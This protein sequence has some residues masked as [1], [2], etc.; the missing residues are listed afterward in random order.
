[1]AD[2][3]LDRVELRRRI[4]HGRGSGTGRSLQTTRPS[5]CGLAPVHLLQLRSARAITPAPALARPWSGSAGA[6]QQALGLRCRRTRK[7]RARDGSPM[8]TALFLTRTSV[9]PSPHGFVRGRSYTAGRTRQKAGCGPPL[10]GG[11]FLVRTTASSPRTAASRTWRRSV[12]RSTCR[13]APQAAAHTMMKQGSGFLGTRATH[14][15]WHLEAHDPHTAAATPQRAA[16]P[17]PR[18]ASLRATKSCGRA[19]QRPAAA[20]SA[21]TSSWVKKR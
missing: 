6:R 12:S 16:H 15:S 9:P 7:A 4:C 11:T 18:L 20:A 2:K 17:R 19:R 5:G 21:V 8:R 13:G 1:M 14:T 3:R 10:L